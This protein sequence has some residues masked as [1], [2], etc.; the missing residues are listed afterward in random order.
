ML[1]LIK[2]E[3]LRDLKIDKI[4]NKQKS[5]FKKALENIENGKKPFEDEEKK[6]EVEDDSSRS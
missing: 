1:K 4:V 3:E 6:E 5:W 2:N